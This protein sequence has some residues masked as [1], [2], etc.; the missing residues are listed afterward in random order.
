V[1]GAIEANREAL[2]AA[3]ISFDVNLAD[4]STLIEVDPTRFTQVLSNVLHN[5][6]KFTEPGGQIRVFAEIHEGTAHTKEA[7]FV[8]ADSGA[9]ISTELLP[10][11]FDLFVQ[12][13]ASARGVRTGLGIGLALAR[14]L[15]EMHGGAI[16]AH[17]EGAG[18]GSTFTIRLPLPTGVAAVEST[19][20]PHEPPH[21]TRRVVVIDDNVDAANSIDRLVGVLGG[22]CRVAYDGATGFAEVLAFHPDIVF[23]DIGMPGIDG[24]EVC[25]RIR[26]EISPDVVIV[27]LTGWGQEQDKADAAGAGFDAHLTK[28]ADPLQLEALLST[29]RPA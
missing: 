3:R 1:N 18:F 21:I 9:G 22:E 17:S 16:D 13:N 14:Q 24:Y 8:V 29:G 10:R 15:V 25:R 23:L 11:V 19:A 26:R 4:G 6:V 20:L 5:A 7:T 27:A 12:D 2:V 28:P